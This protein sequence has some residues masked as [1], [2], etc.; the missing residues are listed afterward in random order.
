MKR[1]FILAI[2][3]MLSFPIFAEAK[4]GKTNMPCVKFNGT[5]NNLLYS[6]KSPEVKS[7]INE[8][9]KTSEGY[10]S[11][12]E[13]IGVHH[14]PNYFSPIYYAKTFREY[15]STNNCP[16]ALEVDEENNSAIID[17]LLIDSS[18]LPIV[19]EFNVFRCEKSPICG[20]VCLQ[21]AKRYTI[22]NALEVDKVKKTFMKNR[23]KYIS[24]IKK[25][26]IPDLIT[27]DVDKGKYINHEGIENSLESELQ[28]N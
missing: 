27:T 13:L 19:L 22:M 15:L 18:K 7:Y 26:E 16:S 17:F 2:A 1:V 4:S 20:T 21:Y 14:Y 28:L 6:A 8:Y 3:V 10:T 25:M 11:W 24:Q 12:T 9:Y 5:K 23:E